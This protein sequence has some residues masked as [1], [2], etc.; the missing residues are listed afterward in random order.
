MPGRPAVVAFDVV[1][2]LFSLD[3]VRERLEDAGL[4]PGTLELWYS[5]LLR[6]GMALTLAGTYCP[7]SQVAAASLESIMAQQR[8]QPTPARVDGVMAAF[9][10]LPL[11]PDALPALEALA[12]ADVRVVALTN[13]GA[14]ATRAL[15]ERAGVEKCFERII[16]VDEARSWKPAAQVYLHAVALCRVR[17]HEL[18]L[19]S[20]HSWDVHGA[21]QAGLV[22]GWAARLERHWPRS[23]KQPDVTGDTLADVATALLVL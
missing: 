6:D 2:T 7:F 13:G 12:G 11:Q 22:T 4:G 10:D 15:I 18:A 1:E 9:R 8:I 3:P 17:P 19:V 16:S 23:M 20:V 5:R 21:H 14:D